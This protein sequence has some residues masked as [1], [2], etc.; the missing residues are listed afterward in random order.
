MTLRSWFQM[1]RDGHSS[2]VKHEILEKLK[3]TSGK[4]TLFGHFLWSNF[5]SPVFTSVILLI[6]MIKPQYS[7]HV[8]LSVNLVFALLLDICWYC[9]GFES[10]KW[11]KKIASSWFK[12]KVNIFENLILNHFH[13]SNW[14]IL[15]GIPYISWV[16]ILDIK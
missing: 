11:R 3:I 16:K 2:L 8:W 15:N 4:P 7:T 5:R 12:G 14:Y 10:C 9:F 6:Q 13:D 1:N